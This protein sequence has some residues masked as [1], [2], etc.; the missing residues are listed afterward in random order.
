MTTHLAKNSIIGTILIGALLAP[1]F[2]FAQPC[3]PRP[4]SG[5]RTPSAFNDMNA[6]MARFH[7]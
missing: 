7:R 2:A 6:V 3:S 1:M 4:G 5:V